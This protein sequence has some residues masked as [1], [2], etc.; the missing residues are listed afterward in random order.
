M[1]AQRHSPDCAFAEALRKRHR[2]RPRPQAGRRLPRIN[3]PVALVAPEPN[4]WRELLDLI[5]TVPKRRIA[6]QEYG[7]PNPN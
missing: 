5:E 2:R 6:V 7:R 1:L 3:V 4:T